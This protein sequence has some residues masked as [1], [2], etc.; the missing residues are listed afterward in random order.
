[1]KTTPLLLGFPGSL[2][3]IYYRQK[4]K[5]ISLPGGGLA[6]GNALE[7]RLGVVDYAMDVCIALYRRP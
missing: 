2:F 5:L 3:N 4:L 6:Y 1:M 7:Y